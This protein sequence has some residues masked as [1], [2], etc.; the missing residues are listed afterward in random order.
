MVVNS[1]VL[2]ESYSLLK[3]KYYVLADPSFF[4]SKEG[5]DILKL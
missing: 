4:T 3:P 2:D 5:Y 1:H